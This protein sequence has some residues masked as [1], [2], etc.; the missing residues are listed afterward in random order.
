LLQ[1]VDA[2]LGTLHRL[3]AAGRHD[4]Q[5]CLDITSKLHWKRRDQRIAAVGERLH[6]LSIG[7]D[8]GQEAAL[9][10]PESQIR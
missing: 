10:C 4:R 8:L 1:T 3:S 5:H 6:R 9:S 7:E 2:P